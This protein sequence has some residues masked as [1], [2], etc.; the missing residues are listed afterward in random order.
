MQNDATIG[1][2]HVSKMKM[3][4]SQTVAE[5]WANE[6]S[7]QDIA[8]CYNSMNFT[9]PFYITFAIDSW[10]VEEYVNCKKSC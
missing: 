1:G 7:Q 6:H 3:K 2:D 4:I 9:V 10:W 5:Y 8:G